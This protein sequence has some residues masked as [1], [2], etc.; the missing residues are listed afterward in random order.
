MALLTL[1]EAELRERTSLKWRTFEPDV[2]PMW[3]AEM[4][5]HQHPAVV[6]ALTEAIRRGD[7]GYP[8]GTA[9]AEAYAAM[10]EHRWGW[11]PEPAQIRRSGDVMNTMLALLVGS[12]AE[13]DHVVINP[14]VYPPFWQVVTGYRRHLTEVALTADARLDLPAIEAALDGPDRPTAYLLCSPHNPTGTLHTAEELTALAQLCGE[15]GVTLIVDEIHAPLT[16]PG[17]TFVPILSLPQAQN[18]VVTFSAGKGWN[19]AA[20]KGGVMIRGTQAEEVFAQ[21][22]PLANQSTG[23]LATIAHTAALTHA[24]GWV[25]D[26]MAEVAA[27]KR[28]LVDLLA[29]HLPQVRHVP[30]P[31]TYLAW[32]DCSALGL[33]HPR[34]HFLTHGKVALNAGEDF[35]PAYGQFVR[36]NLATSEEMLTQGVRRMAASL[37]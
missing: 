32:L 18:A 35:G 29:E 8:H 11:R 5:V 4:D 34:N 20:L 1:T 7:T 16:D 27:R 15:R 6:D 26:L 30:G 2:L 12:T 19:L 22:P 23:H 24:Q 37:S 28:L 17:Q 13:G 25:D 10:A 36:M 9:Y 33:A 14:P 31:A 21:A 3:V